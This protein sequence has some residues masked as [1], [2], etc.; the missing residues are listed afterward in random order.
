MHDTFRTFIL[1]E[2]LKSPKMKLANDESLIR[3][4]LIDSFSLMQIGVF[5]E[6]AWG[7]NVPDRDLT[8]D[9]MDTIDQ[10]VSYVEQRLKAK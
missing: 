3:G 7:F 4:G 5:I 1:T 8:V 2:L 6:E 9:R 10:M